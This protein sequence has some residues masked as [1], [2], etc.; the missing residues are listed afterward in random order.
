MQIAFLSNLVDIELKLCLRIGR[1][2]LRSPFQIIGA[3]NVDLI[4]H[5]FHPSDVFVLGY[6]FGEGNGHQLAS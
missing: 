5:N 2:V 3:R 4:A 6:S 1:D